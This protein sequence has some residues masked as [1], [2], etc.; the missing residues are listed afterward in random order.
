MAYNKFKKLVQLREELGIKDLVRK[1]LPLSV[2]FDFI[3]PTLIEALEEASTE[4]L[5]TEKAKSE[6]IVY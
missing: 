3:S 6:Y 2:S 1:W 4:A 5:T